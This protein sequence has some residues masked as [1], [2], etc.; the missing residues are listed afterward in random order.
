MRYIPEEVSAKLASHEMAYDA[1]KSALI[2]ASDSA[3]IFPV[4]LAHGSEPTNSYAI[5]SSAVAELAGLK[6]GSYWPGN[7]ALGIPRHNSIILLFD[8]SC[9]RI[10]AAVEAGKLNAYRTAAS[11]AV[12]ANALARSDAQT[13]AVFG[14]GHQAEYEVRA[15]ARIRDLQR[16]LVVTRNPEKGTQFVSSLNEEGIAAELMEAEEACRVAEII[17]T[18]TPANAPLFDAAWVQPGTHVASMGSDSKG[19]QELPPQLFDRARLFCDLPAQSRQIGEFQHARDAAELTAIG[20]VLSGLKAG[21]SG[22]DDITVFDSSGLSV[23]DLYVA[24]TILDLLDA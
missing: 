1:V 24:Q 8:Q 12:A 14:A 16:V 9:G 20:E 10:R 3:T 23:Q 17:I 5:K 13:L 15:L 6:V 22:D 18:V 11:N 4:V 7:D 19:K 21:R 2:A